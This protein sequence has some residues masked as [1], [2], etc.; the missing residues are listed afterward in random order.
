MGKWTTLIVI[1]MVVAAVILLTLRVQILE[2]RIAELEAR[3]TEV[4]RSNKG[5][6]ETLD[7][8]AD[9]QVQT[10]EMLSEQF[11]LL[12]GTVDN[13]GTIIELLDIYHP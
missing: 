8:F 5:A 13:V 12:R 10:R 1:A 9:V 2:T 6:W 3:V 11:K 4:E 7:T